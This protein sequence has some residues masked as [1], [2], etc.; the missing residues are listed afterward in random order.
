[1][2]TFPLAFPTVTGISALGMGPRS[3]VAAVPSPFTRQDEV[4]VWDGQQW[5]IEIQVAP[6]VG[7]ANA[8]AWMAFL[9][10][11]NGME[12]TFLFGDPLA[13]T[14]LGAAS[15]TPVVN[16]V[17]SPTLNTRRSR[18][19]YT[20]GWD[21]GVSNVLKAGDFLQLRSGTNARLHM[22][23][24]DANS[25]SSGEA[26]LNLFPALT[27]DMEDGEAIIVQAAKGVFRMATNEPRWNISNSIEH[28]FTIPAYSVV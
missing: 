19:L 24:T 5:V 10:S 4:Q 18:V 21:G 20:R 8:A 27:D 7:R 2:I 28:G 1:M 9:A 23:L 16:T 13:A 17:G 12:G 22:N 14:P 3:V 11:L 6:V 25:D 26:A 15:G